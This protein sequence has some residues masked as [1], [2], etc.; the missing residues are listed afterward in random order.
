MFCK[1]NVYGE[2]FVHELRKYIIIMLIT[3]IKSVATD[4]A[5]NLLNRS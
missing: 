3:M 2:H 1:K 4:A 5:L